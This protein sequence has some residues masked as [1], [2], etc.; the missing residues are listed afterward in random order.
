MN[1]VFKKLENLMMFQRWCNE[2]EDVENPQLFAASCM[3]VIKEF[4]LPTF[5]KDAF[6]KIV[7]EDSFTRELFRVSFYYAL[8]FRNGRKS[9]TEKEKSLFVDEETNNNILDFWN[10]MAKDSFCNS[11]PVFDMETFWNVISSDEFAYDNS[12]VTFAEMFA[13]IIAYALPNDM[14]LYVLEVL[15]T[16]LS[17]CKDED[18]KIVS[19]KL[20][21]LFDGDYEYPYCDADM[22]AVVGGLFQDKQ[23]N[24]FKVLVDMKVV[25]SSIERTFLIINDYVLEGKIYKDTIVKNH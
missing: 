2:F 12:S 5:D 7:V 13:T 3:Y 14:A 15:R 25:G 24:L 23:T 20:A 16:I 17:Y 18:A 4:L 9:Q 8:I 21:T 11:N 22:V 1:N 10:R 19:S 6:A